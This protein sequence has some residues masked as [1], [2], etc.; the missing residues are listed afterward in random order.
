MFR[1]V[2][3]H[4][5]GGIHRYIQVQHISDKLVLTTDCVVGL[6]QILYNQSVPRNMDYIT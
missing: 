6:H 1:R 4:H 3:G 5:Q 2:Q